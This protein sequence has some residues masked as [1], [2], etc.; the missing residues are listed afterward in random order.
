M[1]KEVI[2][3]L[4]ELEK[5]GDEL[6]K[7]LSSADVIKDRN[8]FIS[9]SQEYNEIQSLLRLWR[10]YKDL[11]S[12]I[13]EDKRVLTSG[14]DELKS[15]A[16][17]EIK[18]LISKKEEIE[19]EILELL[20]PSDPTDSRNSIVEIRQGTG[21]EEASLFAA[22]LF[23]MYSKYGERNGWKVEVLSSHPTAMGGFKEIICAL[24][25][26]DVYKKMKYE[27]GV[28]R[29]QRVPITES[30]GRI[31]TSTATVCVLPEVSPIDIQVDPKDIKME[32]FRAGG[33]GGQNVNKVATA[34]RLIHIPTNTVV[35]CQ[36]ER[37][38]YQN[39]ERAM[40]ILLARLY[41]A[42]REEK[43]QKLRVARKQQIGEG[44]RAEKIRTYNYPQNR[45]TDHRINLTLYKL[46][47]ILD[48]MLDEL[49]TALEE[50]RPQNASKRPD[51]PNNSNSA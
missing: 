28:H 20:T 22:V 24:K 16:K 43:E 23:R 37:S 5:R 14:D 47:S 8:K 19:R 7:W 30:G 29:V 9:L 49:I 42:K 38:Q 39:R 3:K 50:A 26:K 51:Y 15:I 27:S 32:T 17:E 35:S 25:G 10:R 18:G 6:N 4:E 48:G 31:H 34:V 11:V 33:H 41:N 21:G 2:S 46:D 45:V 40:R 13:E 12:R 1:N 36:D 44:E